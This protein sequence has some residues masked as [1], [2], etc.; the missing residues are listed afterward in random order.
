MK[1]IK[2]INSFLDKTTMYRVVTLSLGTLV[3]LSLLF[4]LLSF[5]TYSLSELIFSLVS[6]LLIAV[7]TN[8][9]LG[10]VL[11]INVNNESAIITAFIIFFL[12]LPISFGDIQ[13]FFVLALVTFLAIVSKFIITTKGQHF[14]NPAAFGVVLVALLYQAVPSLGYFESSW[15]IGQPAFFVPL[16]IVGLLV[17]AKLRKFI[18]VLVFIGTAFIFYILESWRIGADVWAQ[19]P[20]FWLSGPILFLAFFMF[21]EPFTFPPTRK[22]QV[23]YAILVGFLSQTTL[24]A[25]ILKMTP[26]LAL[27]IGNLVFYHF[28]L[29]QKLILSLVEKKEIAQNTYEFSFSKPADLKFKAGQYLE[30]MLPHESYDNRGIRRYFTI[31]S[32]P[33]DEFIKIGVRFGQGISSYKTKLKNMVVGDKIIASQLAGDF[34]LPEDTSTKLGFIAGGIGITPF[35]SHLDY[36]LSEN[37]NYNTILFNCNNTQAEIAY[38]DKLNIAENRLSFKLVNVLSKENISG[39]ENGFVTEDIIKKHSPDYRER[40][41]YISG[42][43]MMVGNY[44]KLL[45]GMGVAKNKIITDFFPGLA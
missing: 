14:L 3:V 26:E 40:T 7:V 17:V 9:I 8:I 34:T 12:I 30:W 36:M 1:V 19:I 22:L 13:G 41:W 5:I 28:S 35:V 33:K 42:P 18:P 29:K 20:S 25:P 21:T 44:E 23:A 43:P 32:A 39:F 6:I 16:L 2:Y 24:F 27:V 45:L 15:W 10:K 37:K 38:K 4:S 11:N 31:V